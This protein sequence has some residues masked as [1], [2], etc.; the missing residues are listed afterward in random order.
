MGNELMLLPPRESVTNAIW[1]PNS[2]ASPVYCWDEETQQNHRTR[3]R[4]N[5]L[6]GSRWDRNSGEGKAA[7]QKSIRRSPCKVLNYQTS[8]KVFTAHITES[9]RID[10]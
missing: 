2:R 10:S 1:D 3:T 8:L 7:W 6:V 9:V 4:P 5:R